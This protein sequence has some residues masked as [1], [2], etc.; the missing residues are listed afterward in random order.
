MVSRISKKS[1][2]G[3]MNTFEINNIKVILMDD[4]FYE[5]NIVGF[6]VIRDRNQNNR[7]ITRIRLIDR[8]VTYRHDS[9]E[10]ELNGKTF[11]ISRRK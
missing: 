6:V 7:E 11:T 9:V 10:I 2:G 4:N 8:A 5:D 1:Q 3:K